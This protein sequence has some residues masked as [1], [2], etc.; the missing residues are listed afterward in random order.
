MGFTDPPDK[1]KQDRS[2]EKVSVGR[3]PVVNLAFF[4]GVGTVATALKRLSRKVL[5]HLSWETPAVLQD[6]LESRFPA[7]VQ[8]GDA[9]AVDVNCLIQELGELGVPDNTIVLITGGPPC[10]DHSRLKRNGRADVAKEGRKLL[11][12]ARLVRRLQD[13]LP[14]EV[15]FLVEH[16]PWSRRTIAAMNDV[17]RTKEFVCDSADLGLIRRPRIWWSNHVWGDA[18][19]GRWSRVVSGLWQVTI[20]GIRIL[21]AKELKPVTV[22]GIRFRLHRDVLRGL[23]L[24]PCLTRM[25]D[26]AGWEL[27]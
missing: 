24:L 20:T 13:Q 5:A 12:F 4:E 16:V 22:D 18:V 7:I 11:E 3:R 25:A 27:P 10:V 19:P 15:R 6:F 8:K 21:K 23:K 1:I 26:S 9:S 14:W 17:L 2:L